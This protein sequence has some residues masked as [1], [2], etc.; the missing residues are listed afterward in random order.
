MLA[1]AGIEGG[2]AEGGPFEGVLGDEPEQQDVQSDL[3]KI[4]PLAAALAV[5]ASKGD[6]DVAR[7]VLGYLDDLRQLVRLQIKHFDEERRLAIHAAKRKRFSD[8]VRYTALVGA[9]L[10]GLAVVVVVGAMVW[11]A[12]HANGVAVEAFSVP[13]DLAAKGLTGQVLATE[14]QDQLNAMQEDTTSG[15]QSRR[16]AQEGAGDIKVEVPETGVSLGELRQ[17]LRG[18][19]GH[20][21]HVSG[22]IFH[23]GDTSGPETLALTVRVGDAAGQ[24]WTGNEAD[25]DGLLQSSAEKVYASV[26]P[27]R[28]VDWLEQRGRDADAI[29]LLTKLATRGS[30]TQ[31][32]E[33]SFRT[34]EESHLPLDQRI[35]YARR[36]VQLDPRNAEALWGLA[37]VEHAIGHDTAALADLV[38]ARRLPLSSS[39]SAAGRAIRVHQMTYGIDRLLADF[40]D[41]RNTAAGDAK[42]AQDDAAE[43]ARRASVIELD[44]K[45]HDL[46]TP[47]QV[48]QQGYTPDPGGSA[49]SKAQQ[50]ARFHYLEHDYDA[51]TGDWA[52]ALASVLRAEALAK[53]DLQLDLVRYA[54]SKALALAKLGRQAEAETLIATT[55][56]DCYHCLWTRGVI[57]AEKKDWPAADRWFAEAV[58]QGPAIPFAYYYWG[59]AHL[60]KGDLSGAAAEFRLAN[61]TGPHWADPLKA[62]GD[63]LARQGHWKAALAKYDAALKYAPAWTDLHQA[64][65]A[66]ARRAG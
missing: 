29:A 11:D 54:L 46:A 14:L 1:R 18:W 32:S 42:T 17:S 50:E 57:A 65:N 19:L 49:A 64:R 63:V 36:S 51:E 23:A 41:A 2:M 27:F 25:L 39:L 16:A 62:W 21:T 13:P 20:E 45:L 31:M 30:E 15:M 7:G 43:W 6:P 59:Q 61:Q 26:A 8:R 48:V 4:D 9:A 52:G 66:A 38:K 55:P 53:P 60:A 40:Q 34:A 24:R 35:S 28:F 3:G 12:A 56:L 5:D 58:R 47:R 37:S 22:E 33:A 44:V 10:V